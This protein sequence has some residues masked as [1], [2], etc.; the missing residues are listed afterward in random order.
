MYGLAV[1][2]TM[3]PSGRLSNIDEIAKI[4]M[5]AGIN[6]EGVHTPE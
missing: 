5:E 2:R 4:D 1:N 3:S 6:V